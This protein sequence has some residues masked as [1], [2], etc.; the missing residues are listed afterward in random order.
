MTGVVVSTTG[1]AESSPDDIRYG[2]V[3]RPQ[4]V[5]ADKGA[6]KQTR[7]PVCIKITSLFHRYSTVNPGTETY[8]LI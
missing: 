4:Q 2:A 7:L 1:V 5:S 3:N 6:G 8:L